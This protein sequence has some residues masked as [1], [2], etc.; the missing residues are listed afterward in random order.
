MLIL[1]FLSAC[2]GQQWQHPAKGSGEL[3]KDE[4]ECREMA[5]QVGAADSLTGQSVVL[6]SYLESFNRCMLYKGWSTG[7]PPEKSVAG[8]PV[9]MSDPAVL[10]S[11]LTFDFTGQKIT[12]PEKSKIV[13][14]N[15]SDLGG[16]RMQVVQVESEAVGSP[17]QIELI[18]QQTSPPLKFNPILYPI[19]PPFFTYATGRLANGSLWHGFVGRTGDET[20]LGG[21]GAHWVLSGEARVIITI[22]SPL[23]KPD[24]PP[25]PGC[26]VTQAQV[27]PLESLMSYYLPWLNGLG[28]AASSRKWWNF[29]NFFLEMDVG[30]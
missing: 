19:A 7:R 27:Q 23:P 24:Q 28:E 2:G 30:Q 12:L 1:V 11:D 6:T 25:L 13:R 17:A 5:R 8:E 9:S 21:L 3:A 15:L 16:V 10:V 4:A 29:S 18:F 20:W 22:T 26:K 14:N